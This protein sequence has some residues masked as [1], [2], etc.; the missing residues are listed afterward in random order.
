VTPAWKD[1]VMLLKEFLEQRSAFSND[2]LANSF[3][4]AKKE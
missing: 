2:W 3:L 1:E 4:G